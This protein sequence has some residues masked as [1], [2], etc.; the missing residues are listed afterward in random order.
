[1]P[2]TFDPSYSWLK[3]WKENL[4]PP[5]LF[6]GTT[7]NLVR[8]I[9][10][11]GLAPAMEQKNNPVPVVHHILSSARKL[12]D[13]MTVEQAELVLL[14]H[15]E[16][17]P[18]LNGL[19][20]TFNYHRALYMARKK[21]RRL[22]AIQW[23][24][25]TFKDR[26]RRGVVTNR[27]ETP[28]EWMGY[29]PPKIYDLYPGSYGVVVYVSTDLSK[30]QNIPSL[31]EDKKELKRVLRGK[32]LAVKDHW[33]KLPWWKKLTKS[34][35]ERFLE[36][37]VRGDRECSGLGEEVVTFQAIHPSD[38]LRIELSPPG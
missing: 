6:Y 27:A 2:D 33:P 1:M 5:V 32:G 37:I 23:L 18:F 29:I 12:G 36:K 35:M 24:C 17:R 15:G 22:E 30:F 19:R 31:L 34:E 11:H 20:L 4:N 10:E 9:R 38:I 26:I 13:T 7:F 28:A 21:T 8:E 3:T 25:E 16:R 14:E